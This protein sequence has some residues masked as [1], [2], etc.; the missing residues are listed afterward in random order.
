MAGKK[1]HTLLKLVILLL[2]VNV[3]GMGGWLGLSFKRAEGLLA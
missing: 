3:L 1:N 2:L